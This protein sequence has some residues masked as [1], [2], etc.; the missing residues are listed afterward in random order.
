MIVS[1]KGLFSSTRNKDRQK[2]GRD[3][4]SS[5]QELCEVCG[6]RPK[7]IED[8]G[9]VH[10]YCGRTCARAHQPKC[11][12]PHCNASGK[13]AFSGYCGHGH[14]RDAVEQGHAPPC[15][16][17]R[18]QPQAIGDLCLGCNSSIGKSNEPRLRELDLQD[19]KADSLITNFHHQCKGSESFEIGRVYEIRLPRNTVEAREAYNSKVAQLG[20]PRQIQT[21]HS[22]QCICDLGT[23][24]VR[25]CT[26]RSCGICAII[27]SAF[28]AF[29][30]GIKSNSGRFGLGVYSYLEPSLADK[31]AV[32]TTSSPYRAMLACE[33]NLPPPRAQLPKNSEIVKSGEE[34][35]LV[36]VSGAEAIVPKYLILYSKSST[37]SPTGS[38]G[39]MSVHG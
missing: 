21:F 30:F 26:W 38:H 3:L 33:V 12:H 23:N 15:V 5:Q 10:P 14:A 24:G 17:C 27:K 39:R 35:P 28:T 18:R 36:F 11:K 20:L 6:K 2:K 4:S 19:P 22:T 1:L 31:H 37:P 34:G 25:F 7:Y 13:S 29:E 8:T 32:S 9:F 16:E